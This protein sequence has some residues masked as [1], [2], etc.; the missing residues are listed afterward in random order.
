MRSTPPP[1]WR[2][3][4]DD[5]LS[6]RGATGIDHPGGTLFAHVVRVS[7][8][9]RSWGADETLQ[10]AGLCH[11]CYGTAGFPKAL[12]DLSERDLLAGVIGADAETVVHLYAACDRSSVYPRLAAHDGLRW[13]DR[14]TGHTAPVDERTAR[15][16]VELTAANELDLVRTDPA[17]AASWAPEFH[18]LLRGARHRLSPEALAAWAEAMDGTE[19]ARRSGRLTTSRPA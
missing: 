16:L 5:L 15:Q 11:A 8:I 13:T 7:E 18:E 12:L 4:A 10:A 2:V 1:G 14:F 17:S 6:D 3:G 19:P 9:L